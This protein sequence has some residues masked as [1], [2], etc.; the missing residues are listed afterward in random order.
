[1]DTFATDTQVKME[2]VTNDLANGK[3]NN[4]LTIR[5]VETCIGTSEDM[6]SQIETRTVGLQAMAPLVRF[7]MFKV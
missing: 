3:E 6:A 5:S 4:S 2:E 7:Q 1:V